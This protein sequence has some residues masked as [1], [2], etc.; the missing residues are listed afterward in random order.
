MIKMAEEQVSSQTGVRKYFFFAKEKVSS[1]WKDLAFHL[2]FGQAEVDNIAGRNRDDK[3]RCMD[4]LEE[5]LKRN[6]ERATIEALME[7]LSE[8]NL[9]STVDGLKSKYPEVDIP[10]T[11]SS[12]QERK[13][14]VDQM[15]AQKGAHSEEEKSI[16]RAFQGSIRKYYELKLAKFKPLIWN[17]NFALTLSDLFTELELKQTHEK[18]SASA[19]KIKGLDDLFNANTTGKSQ[20]CILIEA[21]PGGGKTTFMSKEAIDAVSQKTELGKRHDIVLLIRL[22][23][24]IEGEAIEEMVW[25]QCVPETTQGVD[26]PAIKA[27]LQRNESRVLFL[28][29]GYDELR[30]EA[31]AEGQAIPK[32]L[33]G[34]LYPNST[35]VITSRPSAGVQQYAQ[36]DCHARIIGFSF[37]LVMKYVRQYFTA[38][39]KQELAQALTELLEEN[40]L[41]RNLVTTPIFLMLVCLLWEEDQAMVSTGTMTG[42]YDN[43]LTCLV[44]K[45]C[46]REGMDMPTDGIPK[47]LADALLQLGKHALDSLLMEETQLDLTE[48]ERQNVNVNLL[49]K[50]G[51]VFA[52]VSA[53][54]LHPRKQLT[55]AHKTMQ[56]FLAGRY[57]ASVAVNEDIGDLLKLTSIDEV[58]EHS[59]LLQF[60]CGCDS[61]VA[62]AVVC[63]LRKFFNTR[64][65]NIHEHATKFDQPEKEVANTFERFALLCLSILTERTEP[66]ILQVVRKWLPFLKLRIYAVDRRQHAALKYFL[67]SLQ[68]SDKPYIM[69]L[70]V[71]GSDIDVV[72]YLEQTFTSPT[73][74]LQLHLTLREAYFNSPNE[75]SRLVS[76]LE[77][78]PGLRALTLLEANLK[79]ETLQPLVRGLKHMALLEQLSLHDIWSPEL[80]DAG[81]EV[82]Q[83]GLD[84]VP[85]L[86][87]LQVDECNVT[88]VSMASL[89]PCLGKLSRLKELHLNDNEI[90]DSG[91][92]SLTTV[93]P[94]FIAMRILSLRRNGFS[95]AGMRTLAPAL[96]H[97]TR[98]HK[99]DLSCN[100]IGDAG[101][102]CLAGIIPCLTV[103]KILRLRKT[104]ISDKGISA[105]V[106]PLAHLVELQI[107]DVGHNIIGERGIVSLVLTFCQPSSLDMEQNPPGDNATPQE[108]DSEELEATEAGQGTVSQLR[109]PVSKLTELY[110]SHDYQPTPVHLSDTAAMAVAEALPRLPALQCLDLSEISMDAAGFNALVQAAEEHPTLR[111]LTYTEEILP[112]GLDTSARSL[113]R[114]FEFKRLDWGEIDTMVHS[115]YITTT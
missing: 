74:G 22:R 13:K 32:L 61:R 73:P 12:Q 88:Q 3:S 100:N 54:K 115:F 20:R 27:I 34:K 28:L 90:G 60:A 83:V 55:F 4:L 25:D 105:L 71:S 10:L 62:Q 15:P 2:G 42:L 17:D 103:M 53:S 11:P 29:D 48:V 6:G 47:D 91:L 109:T 79:P 84:C 30:P 56:E 114:S 59:T 113:K 106:K 64:F 78:V 52:E 37:E 97:L 50:L 102:E 8:A 70:E 43:L 35:V 96:G 98:L 38:V 31:R 36:P 9:Q 51:V 1:D 39:G 26:V 18:R 93:F 112:E 67:Q 41:F 40:N 75:T 21:E 63:G 77:N 49:L 65:A 95:P 76:V 92:G 66:E 108:P 14:A 87:V 5:W 72:E 16:E 85:H 23:E 57:F 94:N 58:V 82:L 86:A 111:E 44:K 68:P 80:G 89:A 107:L 81:M 69:I 24:V 19:A 33:S 104:G 46:K 110:M 101:V 45:H 7:A 99:L